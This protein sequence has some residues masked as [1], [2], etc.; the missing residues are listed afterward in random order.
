MESFVV[1]VPQEPYV[2]LKVFS[3]HEE[4]V[5]D[6]DHVTLDES[7]TDV[8]AREL[9]E[10]P[11]VLVW[12]GLSVHAHGGKKQLLHE[13]SGKITRGFY[14]I[15]GPSGSGKTTLLNTLACRLDHHMKVL[16][17]V[18]RNMRLNER[19]LFSSG[20]F[21]NGGASGVTNT[22]CHFLFIT[23]PLMS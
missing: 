17:K 6:V 21:S 15:M 13:L 19:D 7:L 20:F 4:F 16:V 9:H 18:C 2:E 5:I 23:S 22:A 8:S 1:D 12:K 11:L 3:F 14:A 10:T